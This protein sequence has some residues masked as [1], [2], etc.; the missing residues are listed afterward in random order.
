[1]YARFF[2]PTSRSWSKD[3]EVNNVFIRAH[4]R[5]ANDLLISRGHVFLNE[6][7]DM[8]GLD[9]STAGAAVGWLHTPDSDRGDNF[10]DFGLLQRDDERPR[11]H[12]RHERCR[13]ARLQRRRSDLRQDRHD[14][15]SV[16]MAELRE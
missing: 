12:E 8:L 11:L 4:Q 10:I 9:R 5:Y 1:M 7:Y 13:P 2:D 14:Q 6:V 3:P 15:G 16:V